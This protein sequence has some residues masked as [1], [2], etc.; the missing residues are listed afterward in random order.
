M[1][2]F[3]A[4]AISLRVRGIEMTGAA[5]SAIGYT[6][7][8]FSKRMRVRYAVSDAPQVQRITT[9]GHRSSACG[10]HAL[11]NKTHYIRPDGNSDQHRKGAF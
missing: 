10:G 2:L 5:H 6:L 3:G 8:E 1:D 11:R 9:A 4:T 7:Q